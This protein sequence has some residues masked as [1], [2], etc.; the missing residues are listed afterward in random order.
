MQ[1]TSNF[2]LHEFECSR[3]AQFRG[4][5]NSIK[6]PEIKANILALCKNV[7]QPFR[8][9]LGRE[10]IV[11]SGYRCAQLNE[12]VKGV[13]N[14]QHLLG[15]AADITTSSYGNFMMRDIIWLITHCPFDQVIIYRDFVHVSYVSAEK[16]RRKLL[17]D[18]E[19]PITW[20][21]EVY[22]GIT[23]Y[24]LDLDRLP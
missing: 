23:N 13:A 20:K 2:Q 17:F 19:V 3:T 5:D 15:Q 6:S 4:I 9:H 24:V 22:R 10:V 18:D 11:S 14:S 12:A 16:N 1:L 7:L 8:D 21:V